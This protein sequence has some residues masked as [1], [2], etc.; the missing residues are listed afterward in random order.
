MEGQISW[1]ALVVWEA[2]ALLAAA[3]L[4]WGVD[5][6]L[7]SRS[8]FWYLLLW[9]DGLALVL[10]AFLYLPLRYENCRYRT[11]EDYVEY[12]CGF[13]FLTRNRVMRRAVLYV[14]VFRSPFSLLFRTRTLVVRSMGGS[15]VIPFLPIQDAEAL[16]KDITP[17]CPAVGPRLFSEKGAGHE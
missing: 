15:M 6:L 12:Q 17:R 13:I 11:G 14:T 8:F 3:L 16:L 4:A 9:L 2:A 5:F 7:P 10:A 1:K